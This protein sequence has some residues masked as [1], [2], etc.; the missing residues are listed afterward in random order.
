MRW[1][2]SRGDAAKLHGEIF[3]VFRAL[4]YHGMGHK[5]ALG[6]SPEHRIQMLA[7][8]A[9]FSLHENVQAL[10]KRFLGYSAG[11]LELAGLVDISQQIKINLLAQD[12]WPAVVNPILSDTIH[13]KFN[14]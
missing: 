14:Q 4:V 3:P 6:K 1:F 12:A 9:I 5:T 7:L 11:I 13:N 8:F 2:A 10:L